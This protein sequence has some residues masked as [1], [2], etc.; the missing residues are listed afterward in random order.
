[1]SLKNILKNY[2]EKAK[3]EYFDSNVLA[4][5]L[6]ATKYLVSVLGNISK[7]G[8]PKEPLL[9]DYKAFNKIKNCANKI[10]RNADPYI[11]A[12][13]GSKAT[14]VT[15]VTLLALGVACECAG[16]DVMPQLFGAALT[17]GAFKGTCHLGMSIIDA[18]NRNTIE[19]SNKIIELSNSNKK[20]FELAIDPTICTTKTDAEIASM[21]VFNNG[22]NF[23]LKANDPIFDGCC[24][25]NSR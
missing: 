24:Y 10:C 23:V 16:L 6:T 4:E 14:D 7:D 11:F 8:I 9:Q 13:L 2:E 18:R 17:M 25:D 5:G 1:M 19:E 12:K 15:I 22:H 20:M 3:V 21:E